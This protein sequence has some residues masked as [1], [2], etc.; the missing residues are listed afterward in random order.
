MLDISYCTFWASV[1][2]LWRNVYLDLLPSFLIFWKFFIWALKVFSFLHTNNE[3]SET[4]IKEA[5]TFIIASK[6]IKY[7]GINLPKEAKGLYSE[8]S[9]MLKMKMIE[10]DG[11]ISRQS[12]NTVQ[13]LSNEQW[14]FLQKRNQKIKIYIE[15]QKTMSGQNNFD[16]EEW[17]W[18]NWAPW[19]QTILQS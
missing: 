13:S 14:H 15:T 3:I 11:K 6:R 18:R 4:Q 7:L 17:R 9:K 19:F 5:I 10:T 16:K 2:L 12:I 1:C 8:N